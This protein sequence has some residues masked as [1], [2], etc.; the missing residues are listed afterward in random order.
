MNRTTQLRRCILVLVGLF[1]LP[2]PGFAQTV[3]VQGHVADPQGNVVPRALITLTN[4]GDKRV[5][6]T[7]TGVDE[8]QFSFSG[9]AAGK[10]SL[11]VEVTGFEPNIQTLLVGDTSAP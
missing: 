11:R 5:Q 2:N 6:Q 7:R 8:G 3:S 4:T 10:Y 1:I 9:A